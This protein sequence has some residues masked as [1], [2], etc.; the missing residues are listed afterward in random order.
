MMLTPVI[1]EFVS[2]SGW[3]DEVTTDPETGEGRLA[4]IVEIDKQSYELYVESDDRMLAIYLYPR[5]TVVEGKSV[6]VV[7]FFNYMNDRFFYPGRLTL[8]DDNRIRYR[9]LIEAVNLEPSHEMIHNML[10]SGVSLFRQHFEQIA[11]IA[12]TT[13]TYESI[14]SEYDRKD[15]LDLWNEPQED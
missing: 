9:D 11:A 6:D 10:R 15:E 14:R 7:L 5:F 12:L 2:T 13:K 1:E 8:M 4:T 3:D